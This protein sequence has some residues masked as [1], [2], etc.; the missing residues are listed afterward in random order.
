LFHSYSCIPLFDLL[1]KPTL[2]S[3]FW[4]PP[5]PLFYIYIY[6]F[7]VNQGHLCRYNNCYMDNNED[8]V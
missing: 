2:S 7:M 6:I 5:T 3:T 1:Q 8:D 4:S